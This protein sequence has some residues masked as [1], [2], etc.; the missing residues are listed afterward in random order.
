M[1]TGGYY[2][3][4][5]NPSGVTVSHPETGTNT[6]YPHFTNFLYGWIVIKTGSRKSKCQ[7][8]QP[9]QIV[10]QFQVSSIKM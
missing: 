5:T 7:K 10:I 3:L 2:L 1:L 9:E 6:T 8:S 4:V